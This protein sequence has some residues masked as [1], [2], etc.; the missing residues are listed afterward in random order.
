MNRDENSNAEGYAQRF[1][2]VHV[3]YTSLRRTPKRSFQWY[4]EL[5]RATNKP[6]KG[7][8][9]KKKKD[10]S[11]KKKDKDKKKKGK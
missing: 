2:L 10:K 1:G 3:D 4:A 6:E 8:K 7:K 5:I 11:A 9:G